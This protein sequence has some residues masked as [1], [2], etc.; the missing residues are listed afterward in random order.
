MFRDMHT[1]QL[2]LS[3]GVRSVY[4]ENRFT[5]PHTYTPHQVRFKTPVEHWYLPFSSRYIVWYTSSTSHD[6]TI[7]AQHPVLNAWGVGQHSH[8][9]GKHIRI[10]ASITQGR[11]AVFV[12]TSILLVGGVCWLVDGGS[13]WCVHYR[14]SWI[15]CYAETSSTWLGC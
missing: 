3:G 6:S 7:P 15:R 10:P 12:H 5:G 14:V 13:W 2:V 11:Q 4:S 1:I 9:H 8:Y